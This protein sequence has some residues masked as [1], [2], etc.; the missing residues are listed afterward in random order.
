MITNTLRQQAATHIQLRSLSSV[1][2]NGFSTTLAANNYVKFKTK[3]N[4]HVKA[5]EEKMYWTSISQ[6]L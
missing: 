5:F 3:Y 6:P 1:V 4:E 2:S